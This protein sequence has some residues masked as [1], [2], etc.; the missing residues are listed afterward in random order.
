MNHDLKTTGE[1]ASFMLQCHK[2]VFKIVQKIFCTTIQQRCRKQPNKKIEI[3]FMV[4]NPE[5]ARAQIKKANC[6][7]PISSRDVFLFL[8]SIYPYSLSNFLCFFMVNTMIT[9]FFFNHFVIILSICNNKLCHYQV[10]GWGWVAG[11]SGRRW[12]SGGC[13]AGTVDSWYSHHPPR[14]NSP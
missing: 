12:L 1:V 4:M 5:G 11:W 14:K 10:C 6:W 9:V 3:W 8:S 2:S 7:I 13:G